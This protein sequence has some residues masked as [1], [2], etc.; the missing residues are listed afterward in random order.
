MLGLIMSFKM[1]YVIA[2]RNKYPFLIEA[3]K[4]LLVAVRPDE[5]IVVIDGAS[6]DGSVEFL[7]KLYS[8][9]QIHQFVSEPDIGEAHA[10][11]KGL[12]LA[13]GELIKVISDDDV[14]N[15]SAIQRCREFMLEHTEVSILATDGAGISTEHKQGDAFTKW[16]STHEFK[17]LCDGKKTIEFC[18]LGLMFRRSRLA[19]TGLLH[20]GIAWID[21]E[22]TY[23]I[24]SAPIT[25][26]WF[27]GY[28]WVRISNPHSSLTVRRKQIEIDWLRV[29]YFY[30]GR[31]KRQPWKWPYKLKAFIRNTL[32][33]LY[34]NVFPRAQSEPTQKIE[35]S[36]LYTLSE[37]WMHN[38]HEETPNQILIRRSEKDL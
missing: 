5:E 2:T 8:Q 36:D 29:D 25:I 34:R 19:L 24:T 7:Q 30:T 10:W 32:A 13:R 35:L 26:G 12:L 11:N 33:R 18:G 14:F 38:Q 9:G 21:G 3:I 15:Y 31:R 23:R 22:F 27:T 4:H 1:S 20:T 16:P 28:A 17:K 6:T 37:S